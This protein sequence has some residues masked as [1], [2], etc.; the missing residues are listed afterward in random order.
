MPTS[1]NSAKLGFTPNRRLHKNCSEYLPVYIYFLFYYLIYYFLFSNNFCLR[2]IFW[3]LLGH[4]MCSYAW[5][6]GC[7]LSEEKESEREEWLWERGKKNPQ[8]NCWEAVREINVPMLRTAPLLVIISLYASLVSTK[9]LED[10]YCN[11]KLLG[12]VY[13]FILGWGEVGSL[14]TLNS[15][16]P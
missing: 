9:D 1:T 8:H 3:T 12:Q 16:M 15:Q 13:L 5:V 2:A 7:V 6:C 10:P 4:C 11:S 14:K